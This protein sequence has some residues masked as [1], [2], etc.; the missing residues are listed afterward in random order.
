MKEKAIK[1]FTEVRADQ[2]LPSKVIAKRAGV[3][4]DDTVKPILRKLRD[5]GKIRFD[6]GRWF[7]V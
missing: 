2:G 6:E 3:E 5:A 7:R 1:L 4:Y